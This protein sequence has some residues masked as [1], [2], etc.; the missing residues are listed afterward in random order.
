MDLKQNFK[1][2]SCGIFAPVAGYDLRSN[3]VLAVNSL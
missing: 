1:K 3:Q 2:N